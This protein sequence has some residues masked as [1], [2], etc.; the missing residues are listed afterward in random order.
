MV[1]R[2]TFWSRA[3]FFAWYFKKEETRIKNGILHEAPAG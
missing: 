3:C 1:Q 2:E